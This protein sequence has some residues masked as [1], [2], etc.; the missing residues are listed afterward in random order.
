MS[1]CIASMEICMYYYENEFIQSDMVRNNISQIL[2]NISK[3]N[4]E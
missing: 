1:M 4:T 2:K 3:E